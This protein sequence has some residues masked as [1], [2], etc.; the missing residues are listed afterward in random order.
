MKKFYKISIQLTEA[1][2]LQT[3]ELKKRGIVQSVIYQAGLH[4]YL[5][6]NQIKEKICQNAIVAGENLPRTN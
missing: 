2:A 3:Q 6:A 4:K 5:K 1:A